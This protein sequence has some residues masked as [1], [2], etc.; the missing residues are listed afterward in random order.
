MAQFWGVFWSSKSSDIMVR[1]SAIFRGKVCPSSL[2]LIID[3]VKFFTKL[4]LS[5]ASLQV[6]LCL[7]G[8]DDDNMSN[9]VDYGSNISNIIID[10]INWVF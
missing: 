5:S 6:L 4:S 3:I 10:I 7:C 1:K 9:Y 8:D 2:G